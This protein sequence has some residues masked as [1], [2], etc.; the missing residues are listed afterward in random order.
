MK[1]KKNESPAIQCAWRYG[2]NTTKPDAPLKNKTLF[3]TGA[4]RGIGR[5]IAL[6][7]AAD[8]A[9]VVIA[10]K[11][12]V[13]DDRLPGTIHSVAAEVEA[14]GGRPLAVVLDIRDEAQVASAVRQAAER[15]GGIDILVNN[16]SAIHPHGLLDT[17]VKKYDLMMDINVRGT[18]L[19]SQACMPYLLDSVNPHILTLSPPIDLSP[20]WFKAHP[21]YTASK[22][23]M[24]MV[25]LGIAAEYGEGRISCNGLWPRTL[26]GTSALR[27]AAPGMVDRSRKPDIMADAAHWIFSQAAGS[28]NGRF[29][30][31]EEVLRGAGMTSFDQYLTTPGY[32]PEIDYFVT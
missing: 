30:L 25:A 6:R 20:G 3:I 13:Q 29:F 14:A 32:E 18:Y 22:Y 10:A 28:N 26:I 5:A 4:S 19:C 2:V 11:T 27:L 16:A 24:S 23:A 31:D 17:P 8:G 7:A 12:T 21:A 9:N 1:E 15:F